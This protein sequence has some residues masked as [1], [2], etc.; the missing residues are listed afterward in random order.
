[1]INIA[2]DYL[3]KGPLYSKIYTDQWEDL[4]DGGPTCSKE[5]TITYRATV[6]VIMVYI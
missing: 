6:A 2:F 3:I 5:L 4:A 1:M